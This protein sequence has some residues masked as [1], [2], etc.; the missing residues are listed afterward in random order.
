M[1]DIF[2]LKK[3]QERDTSSEIYNIG[4]QSTQETCRTFF[5][6]LA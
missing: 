5:K 4:Q 3:Q 2:H 6:R 1:V